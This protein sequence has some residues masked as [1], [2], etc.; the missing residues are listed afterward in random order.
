MNRSVPGDA[1]CFSSIGR[2]KKHQ[3]HT[4]ELKQ[5][6]GGR[7]WTYGELATASSHTAVFLTDLGKNPKLGSCGERLEVRAGSLGAQLLSGAQWGGNL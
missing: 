4:R 6:R 2:V 7:D 1:M 3:E 5:E